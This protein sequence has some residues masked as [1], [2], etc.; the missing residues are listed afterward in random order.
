MTFVG[1]VA[2]QKEFEILQT[3]MKKN[4]D[5]NITLITDTD[6]ENLRNVKFDT[7]II[8]AN[9]Q[10]WHNMKAFD[11]ICKYAQY[12]VV[13]TD[14]NKNTN[15][16][17]GK[18]KSVITYGL[19]HKCTITVS[20]VKEEFIMIAIQREI[21]TKNGNLQEIG[22]ERIKKIKKLDIYGHMILVIFNILYGKFTKN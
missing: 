8:D 22:E 19:N 7:I 21:V 10:N 6:I 18:L 1:I 17:K 3:V 16:L 15:I 4:K 2:K 11:N 13:N 12:L 9:M 5:I 20:S 14:N